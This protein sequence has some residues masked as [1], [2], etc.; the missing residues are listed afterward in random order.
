MDYIAYQA[1]LSI[2]F[3]KQEYWTGLPFLF[4]GGLPQSGIKLA[5]PALA[6]GFFTTESP[7]KLISMFEHSIIQNL[8]PQLLRL[9]C[10]LMPNTSRSDTS[11]PLVQAPIL[12]CVLFTLIH[13]NSG[14]EP[15]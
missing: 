2:G 11:L 4:P 3:S 13:D 12:F 5:S 6:G 7:E 1:P 15:A 9:N 8:I 10:R 14:R